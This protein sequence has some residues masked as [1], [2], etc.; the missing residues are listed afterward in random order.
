MQVAESQ[1]TMGALVV[2]EMRMLYGSKFAQQWQGLTARELKES[3]D[4][5]LSGLGERDVRRGLV[6][7]LRR[8]WPPT[9]PEFLRLCCPWMDTEVAYHEAVHGMSCRRRGEMGEWSHPAVYWAAVGISSND[10]LQSTYSSIKGRWEKMLLEEMA[11]GNWKPIPQVSVSLPAPKQTEADRVE[12]A[13]ALKSMGADKI[14]DQSG[15][16]HRR[17][18]GKLEERIAKG[19]VLSPTVMAMLARAKGE[20]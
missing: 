18:I 9:L 13:K 16:D 8:D 17:W 2:N 3:W 14:F 15:K 11:K 10:L 19:E 5:K 20:A 12:A 4:Q 7:C 1:A 6:A